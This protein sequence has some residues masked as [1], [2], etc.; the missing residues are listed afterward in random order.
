M[1]A[2]KPELGASDQRRRQ[3]FVA[4]P[5]L[6]QFETPG[7]ELLIGHAQRKINHQHQRRDRRHLEQARRAAPHLRI[8]T[9]HVQK[10]K[11]HWRKNNKKIK[12]NSKAIPFSEINFVTL[13]LNRSLADS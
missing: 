10:H 6:E 4:Q 9:L 8:Q 7:S 1:G 3:T 5:T 2:K 12:I 13:L 11:L